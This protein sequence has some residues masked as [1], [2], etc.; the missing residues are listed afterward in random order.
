MNIK[1]I[2]VLLCALEAQADKVKFL[3]DDNAEYQRVCQI[4]TSVEHDDPITYEDKV[5]VRD[6]L[7]DILFPAVGLNYEAVFRANFMTALP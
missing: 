4:I 6:A 5:F 3:L 7:R 1:M 2:D